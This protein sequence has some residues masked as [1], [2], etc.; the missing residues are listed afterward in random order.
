MHRHL[1]LRRGRRGRNRAGRIESDV[2]NYGDVDGGSHDF[3]YEDLLLNRKSTSGE[4]RLQSLGQRKF[5]WS[6]G[7]AIGEDEGVMDQ[8]TYHGSQSPQG[9]PEGFEVTGGDSDG[10]SKYWAVFGQATWRFAA[11]PYFAMFSTERSKRRSR[12]VSGRA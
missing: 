10:S 4:L 3:Y 12:T 5:E 9:L 11:S 7:A 1:V 8:S 6:I 2:F